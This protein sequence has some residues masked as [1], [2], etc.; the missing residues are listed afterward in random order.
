MNQIEFNSQLSLA[1]NG[2]SLGNESRI[3]L[4]EKIA[5]LGSITHAAKAAGVSYKTAWDAIEQMNNLAGV[6]LVERVAGGKGGGGT[7]LTLR[8][9]SLL[10]NFK[11]IQIEQQKFLQYLTQTQTGLAEDFLLLEQLRMQSSARNQFLG[12]V[13]RITQGAVNDEVELTLV[14]GHKITAT[15]TRNSTENLQLAEG[16]QAYALV[17]SSSVILVVGEND[18]K[19][20]IRNQLTGNISRI[21]EGA[22]NTEV[23]IDLGGG[24]SVA[25]IITRESQQNL[26]LSEGQSVTAAFKASSVILGRRV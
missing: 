20:S 23:S 19:L 16:V 24:A 26:A 11:R 13:S 21:H 6:A 17:K 12:T 15:I 1:V 14:G 10:E 3:L 18:L 22:V 7:A 2:Q 25:A 8:G 9:V 5:E 4:L